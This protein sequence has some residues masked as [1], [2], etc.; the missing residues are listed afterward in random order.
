[1]E[2]PEALVHTVHTYLA[3]ALAA[4]LVRHESARHHH[5][6]DAGEAR[7]EGGIALEI[8]RKLFVLA[9][10][11]IVLPGHGLDTTVGNERP[12]LD[13]WVERGW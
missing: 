1:M 5:R 13:E 8:D 10:D 3:G 6:R 9:P 11:T 12:H 2:P 7:T 4:A